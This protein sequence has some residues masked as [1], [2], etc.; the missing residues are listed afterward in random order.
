M[1]PIWLVQ[2]TPVEG[3]GDISA[4]VMW[5]CVYVCVYDIHLHVLLL[6]NGP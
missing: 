6:R 2:F 5:G 4:L 1:N 3:S